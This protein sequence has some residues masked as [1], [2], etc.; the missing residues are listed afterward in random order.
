MG[1]RGVGAWVDRAAQLAARLEASS[2]AQGKPSL[3]EV[4]EEA[5]LSIA[6][7]RRYVDAYDHVRMLPSDDIAISLNSFEHLKTWLRIDPL[8]ATAAREAALAG[9]IPLSRI[10]SA[11][12]DARVRASVPDRPEIQSVDVIVER[13]RAAGVAALPEREL[14]SIPPAGEGWIGLAADATLMMAT[15]DDVPYLWYRWSLVMSPDLPGSPLA[16]QTFEAFL[17][18]VAA[19]AAIYAHVSAVCCS[20]FERDEVSKAARSWWPNELGRLSIL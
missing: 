2:D 10:Q 7:V 6:M 4:A 3:K 1:R 17:L 18:R 12:R 19:A 20:E 16:G 13:F 5:G 9:R 15:D 14:V 8:A 11:I